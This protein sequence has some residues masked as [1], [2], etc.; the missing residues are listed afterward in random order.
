MA[1]ASSNVRLIGVAGIA[2]FIAGCWVGMGSSNNTGDPYC[3]VTGASAAGRPGFLPGQLVELTTT[4]CQPGEPEVCG[5]Y[6]PET[7]DDRRFVSDTCPD[8]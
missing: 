2:A 8:D 4:D 7:G 5:K 6:E 1:S 3:V